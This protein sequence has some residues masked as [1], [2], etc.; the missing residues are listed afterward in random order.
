MEA[1]AQETGMRI[2]QKVAD[3]LF[4]LGTGKP[5]SLSQQQQ[6]LLVHRQ[7]ES[8]MGML[9]QG[10]ETIAQATA[11]AVLEVARGGELE[12]SLMEEFQGTELRPDFDSYK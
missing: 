9:A 4:Q 12:K 5:W 7:P 2:V 3:A 1:R 10:G 6:A 8:V 11:G